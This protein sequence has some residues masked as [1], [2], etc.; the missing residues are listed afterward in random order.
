MLC[1]C[2]NAKYPNFFNVTSK[3]NININRFAQCKYKLKHTMRSVH[4]DFHTDFHTKCC[5][6]RKVEC[7]LRGSK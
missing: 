4:T 1:R 5:L 7:G 3:L 2:K 6:I